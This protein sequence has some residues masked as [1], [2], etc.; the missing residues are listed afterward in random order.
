L[1]EHTENTDTNSFQITF[2]YGDLGFS[3]DEL[4][5]IVV[6]VVFEGNETSF[7]KY[8]NSKAESYAG[9]LHPI[10]AIVMSFLFYF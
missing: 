3:S 5:K 4:L 6:T 2:F 8:F 7:F 9:M 10:I 1:W